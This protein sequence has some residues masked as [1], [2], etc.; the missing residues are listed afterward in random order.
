[1]HS[2]LSLRKAASPPPKPYNQ[3]VP[4][5]QRLFG[6]AWVPPFNPCFNRPLVNPFLLPLF[7]L[8]G[9]FFPRAAVADIRD[10]SYIIVESGPGLALI[11]LLARACPEA[12]IIYEVSDRLVT[13]G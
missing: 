9:R 8:Y 12:K 6:M 1:G 11:P 13:V 7:S 10:A 2:Y 4:L 3:W 5:A